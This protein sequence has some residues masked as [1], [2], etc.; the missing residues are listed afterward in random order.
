MHLLFSISTGPSLGQSS[1]ISQTGR[2]HSL[3]LSMVPGIKS[4][5]IGMAH[6]NLLVLVPVSLLRLILHTRPHWLSFSSGEGTNPLTATGPLHHLLP[7]HG[8]LVNFRS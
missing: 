6:I 2:C 5:I 8:T 4:K 3:W 1:I 7:W